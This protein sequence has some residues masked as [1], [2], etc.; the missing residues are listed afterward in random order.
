MSANNYLLIKDTEPP[1]G[2][3]ELSEHNADTGVEIQSIASN[4]DLKELIKTAK[5]Y[6]R[7]NLIEYELHF[8]I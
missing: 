3:Y 8:D 5:E 2:D 7:K 6:Q 1:L 4:G